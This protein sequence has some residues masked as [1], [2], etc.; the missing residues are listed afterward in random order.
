MTFLKFVKIN[1][2]EIRVHRDRGVACEAGM[3]GCDAPV[4]P[5]VSAEDGNVDG[6][7]VEEELTADVEQEVEH[8]STLPTYQ[9]TKSEYD[10]HCVTHSP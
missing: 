9:P 5:V 7:A 2:I 3:C 10:E 6:G 4:L 8:V 1:E